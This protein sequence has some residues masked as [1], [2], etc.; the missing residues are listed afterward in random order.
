MSGNDY[1]EQKYERVCEMLS[2]NYPEVPQLTR[3]SFARYTVF[4]IQ[5]G[6]FLR[7]VLRNDLR[8]AVYSADPHNQSAL[9]QIIYMTDRV[10]LE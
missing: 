4:G 10:R 5:P 2:K 1:N 7:A 8:L 6:S 3:E 9:L